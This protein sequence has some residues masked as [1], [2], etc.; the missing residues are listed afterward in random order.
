MP[1]G[2]AANVAER[3]ALRP[4][5]PRA[6]CFLLDAIGFPPGQAPLQAA[7]TLVDTPAFSVLQTPSSVRP[8]G[9]PCGAGAIRPGGRAGAG[10][11]LCSHLCTRSPT[12]S[13]LRG[14]F[15]PQFAEG[16]PGPRGGWP[17]PSVTV[18]QCQADWKPAPSTGAEG[19]RRSEEIRARAEAGT[20]LSGDGIRLRRCP[21]GCQGQRRTRAPGPRAA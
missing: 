5:C 16:P 12:G 9:R 6:S 18:S 21:R 3:L 14:P 2:A 11:G 1:T 13:E 4:P 15:G 19:E 20:Q 8:G 7:G 10:G 17:W